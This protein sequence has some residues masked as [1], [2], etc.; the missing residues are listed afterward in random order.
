MNQCYLHKQAYCGCELSTRELRLSVPDHDLLAAMAALWMALPPQTRTEALE[1]LV[2]R[3]PRP[4]GKRRGEEEGGH[5]E[6]SSCT[7]DSEWELDEE[8]VDDLEVAVAGGEKRS[9][10]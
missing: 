9:R 4:R 2:P 3:A 6:P 8:E 5:T 1:E 7:R 10:V